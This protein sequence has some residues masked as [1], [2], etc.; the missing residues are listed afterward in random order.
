MPL[1][2]T[3]LRESANMHSE[4]GTRY[5]AIDVSSADYT[6]ADAFRGFLVG[7]AGAVNIKGLD[8][9][10]C[11]LPSVLA[12]VVYPCSG[13]SILSSGTDADDIVVI[14]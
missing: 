3:A 12:G 9:V 7:T 2:T 10:A 6:P 13:T 14:F 8:G 4:G 1:Y 11:V 5:V